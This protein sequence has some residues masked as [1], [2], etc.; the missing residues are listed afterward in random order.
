MLIRMSGNKESKEL[1]K[2]LELLCTVAWERA[3]R[4]ERAALVEVSG[5][6]H[7]TFPWEI[8]ST[9][10][11]SSK[12]LDPALTSLLWDELPEKRQ[13]DRIE[14]GDVRLSE[15]VCLALQ[16]A[17][18]FELGTRL[19]RVIEELSRAGDDRLVTQDELDA[20]AELVGVP[21]GVLSYALERKRRLRSIE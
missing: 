1:K 17:L 21:R 19:D 15:P 12:H 11:R 13:I 16:M 14:I 6:Y 10:A 5:C 2:Q 8:F 20:K 7:V 3:S 4:I 9:L 18:A